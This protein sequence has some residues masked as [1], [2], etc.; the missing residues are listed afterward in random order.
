[1]EQENF[2]PESL[3]NTCL[4]EDRLSVEE[5]RRQ[6]EY[7]SDLPF[8]RQLID[9]LSD[10]VL[11][12]NQERQIVLA[13]RALYEQF[14]LDSERVIASRPGEC[15]NC[16]HA[17][18]T[19]GGCGTSDF[20]R[21]CG[22]A[23]ALQE[24]GSSG[25]SAVKEC[26]IRRKENQGSLDLRI[27]AVPLRVREEDFSIFV[28]TDIRHEKRRRALEQVFFNDILKMTWNLVG[29][30]E[31]LQDGYEEKRENYEK[32][33]LQTSRMILQEINDRKLLTIAEDNDLIVN[34]SVIDAPEFLKET[35]I[36]YRNRKYSP[37]H[38]RLEE[39]LP[40][41]RFVS[42]RELLR[43]VIEKMTDNAIEFCAPDEKVTLGYESDGKFL[44]FWVHNPG[45]MPEAARLQVFQ[46]SF[47][48]RAKGRG[49]GTYSIR[50]LSERYLKGSV[51]F[52]TSKEKGTVFRARYP[53]TLNPDKRDMPMTENEVEK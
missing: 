16:I 48:T 3:L 4:P 19:S 50:L 44:T 39:N 15:L 31:L 7:F 47:S 34:P 28:I 43:S 26:R 12:L 45:E 52:T 5:V 53:L 41:V 33:I 38:I 17:F 36:F 30:A 25:Q 42:D 10:I 2:S 1:M 23:K 18:K 6:A 49:L 40:A 8:F 14:G 51:S 21:A 13:N 37:G 24:R 9:S 32:M 11:I 27:R 35:E 46:R 29:F 20:C 22:A